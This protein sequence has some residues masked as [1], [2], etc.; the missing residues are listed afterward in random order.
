MSFTG[1]K[2]TRVNSYTTGNQEHSAIA[3]LDGG[4]WVVTWESF[5]QDGELDGIYSQR[6]TALGAKAGDETLVNT[7]TAHSQME[8]SVTGIQ[9]G[10]YVVTWSDIGLDGSLSG[11][12]EQAY[13]AEG[14]A[15]GG[16]TKVNT[17]VNLD[18]NSATVASLSDGGWV[19][20]WESDGQDGDKYGVYFQVYNVLMQ[21]SGGEIRANSTTTGDQFDSAVTGLS[22]GGWVVTWTSYGNSNDPAGIFQQAYANNGAKVGS[23]TRVNTITAGYQSRQDVTALADGNWVVTWQS[24]NQDGNGYGIYQQVFSNTG[25]KLGSEI[26]VNKTTADNQTEPAVAMLKDGG[27]VVVWESNKQDAS[28]SGIFIQTFDETGKKT[29]GEKRVNQQTD[30]DQFDADVSVLTDG[31]IVVSWSSYNKDGSGAAISQRIF[32][33]DIIGSDTGEKLTGTARGEMIV[34]K[35]GK[36]VLL[37][38]DGNDWL[39]GGTGYD[40]LTGGNGADTF[41]FK[42]GYD[43]DK[44]TDFGGKDVVDLGGLKSIKNFADLMDNHARQSGDNVVIDGLHGDVLVLV[45]TNLKHL[46]ASDFDF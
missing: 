18:Q 38:Q 8:P 21:K 11:I 32:T 35:G 27:W 17:T 45:D 22:N 34:G 13:S 15:T 40:R 43:R 19:V 44:I 6:Y 9:G 12:Y 14:I 31:S 2:E 30:G 20:S 5:G 39:N 10:G 26:L 37:G 25:A 41:I 29:G 42:T 3:A 7:Q 24:Q 23:E 28:G 36:D 46:H 33:A 4:G 16:Q 1:T